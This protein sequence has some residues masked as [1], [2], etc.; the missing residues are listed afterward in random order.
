[1][2]NKTD[3][4]ID[5]IKEAINQ[6]R[7]KTGSK[8]LSEADL[9]TKF[10]LSRNTVR[11]AI[12]SLCS[13][14]LIEKK[15]GSG[16]YITDKFM[17]NKDKYIIIAIKDDTLKDILGSVYRILLELIKEEIIKAGYKPYIYIEQHYEEDILK[18][19]NIERKYIAGIVILLFK[20][21]YISDDSIPVVSSV[22][23]IPTTYYNIVPNYAKFISAY[24]SLINKYK[25]QNFLLVISETNMKECSDVHG[26]VPYTM[27]KYLTRKYGETIYIPWDNDF[28]KAPEILKKK[29]ASMDYIPDAIIFL[30]DI[31]FSVAS[32]AFKDIKD[33]LSKTKII[34]HSN[35]ERKLD[36]GINYCK[37]EVSLE[38]F[39]N[40]SIQLL[41][42]LI[43]NEFISK[44]NTLISPTIVNE[45]ALE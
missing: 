29:L 11:E 2:I 26:L 42:K 20:H 30:D 24:E 28:A 8:L 39:A 31:I 35:K 38:E 7:L 12:G 13:Q 25:F 3:I 36:V 19:V 21:F 9:A 34:S 33:V 17:S 22:G 1:M 23:Y 4:I 15:R 18:A 32:K 44:P 43:N 41:Q 45:E 10:N 27:P 37:V 16:N 6:G 14:G 5:Y 40:K